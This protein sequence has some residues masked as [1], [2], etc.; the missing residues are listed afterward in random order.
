M[1][2]ISLSYYILVV[3]AVGLYYLVPRKR[4]WI[5]LW[6]ASAG[7]YFLAMKNIAQLL[8]FA[9]SVLISYLAGRLLQNV[10]KQNV[11]KGIEKMLLAISIFLSA[12]P[13][14]ISKA[15]DFVTGSILHRPMIDWI[16]PLGLS[17]YTM[18]IIAYLVDIYRGKIAPQENLLKYSLFVSFF[19]LIIQ[20]PISRYDQLGEQLFT[21]HPYESQNLMKG[22]QL[23]IWGFFLKLVIADKAAVVVNT[24]FGQN[25]M[26]V[27]CYVLVAAI[28]YS[29]QL[30]ADFLSCV[31]MSRGVAQLF[32]ID[33]IHN[34]NHPYFSTSIKE[35]WRRWHISLSHWL[36]DYIYIPLGGNRRGKVAKYINL[37]ITFAV[38]GLWHGGSWKYLFWGLMHAGYQIAGELTYPIRD[39]LFEKNR[40]PKGAKLRK[41][42]G[43]AF[44]FVFVMFAW[45][46]FRASSLKTGIKMIVSVFADFNPWILF[47]GSV[48]S[49]GLSH[50]EFE[51]L[52]A[53][54]LVLIF[55]S[56]LQ[57]RGVRLRE[58]FSKQNTVIRWVIYLC[59]IWCIWIFGT[60]GFGFNA[61]DFIY[62]GF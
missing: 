17:F 51:V 22:I 55:V 11:T 18:Q 31:T 2:Y 42:I 49:L 58:W 57:E 40:L 13:L 35:F 15:G 12:A 43:Q 46:I 33:V 47:N 59:A 21:G 45:I 10:R 50:R 34:F 39:A 36:R 19:P 52:F 23:I 61:Q 60:Y 14:L 44:T 29:L 30:Y 26:Y 4:R 27:G 5:I 54:V 8:V 25:E 32:G 37:I 16:L 7:F 62:G 38:S 24:V 56:V 20:G 41:I 3:I 28:L 48:Y 9:G 6:L 1:S 53:A